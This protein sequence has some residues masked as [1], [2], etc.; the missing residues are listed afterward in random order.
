VA[1]SSLARA[2][3]Y[4]TLA[5]INGGIA[6]AYYQEIPEVSESR[7]SKIFSISVS[8]NQKKCIFAK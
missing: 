7:K 6:E 4:D 3:I 5:C 1:E 8:Q 2:G